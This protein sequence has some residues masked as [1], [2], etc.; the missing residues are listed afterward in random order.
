MV[1]ASE[2]DQRRQARRGPRSGDGPVGSMFTQLV[3][4][5]T[6]VLVVKPGEWRVRAPGDVVMRILKQSDNKFDYSFYYDRNDL[7]PPD[8]LALLVFRA[9]MLANDDAARAAN[10]TTA[11][12]ATF[13][14]LQAQ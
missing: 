6:G 14:K 3:R 9:E 11:Q 10:I 7:V 8:E 12:M 2:P 5:T 13:K 4:T 1:V